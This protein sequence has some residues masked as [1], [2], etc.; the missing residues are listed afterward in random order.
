MCHVVN[1]GTFAI[2]CVILCFFVPCHPPLSFSCSVTLQAII[3][4]G[5]RE[6]RDRSVFFFFMINA[7][8]VI[9]VFLMQ[10]NKDQLHFKWPFGIKTNVTLTESGDVR[11]TRSYKLLV[12]INIELRIIFYI[13]HTIV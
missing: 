12:H 3:T 5:L 7:I 6:L 8:F 9:I 13:L 10:L 1:V 2:M 4:Q 11:K